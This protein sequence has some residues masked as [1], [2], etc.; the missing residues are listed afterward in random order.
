M[1][2]YAISIGCSECG[3]RT[4]KLLSWLETN[5]CFACQCGAEVNFSG[6]ELIKESLPLAERLFWKPRKKGV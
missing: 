3:H 2:D 4:N 6:H 1:D 5:N